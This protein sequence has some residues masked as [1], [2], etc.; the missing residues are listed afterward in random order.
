MFRRIAFRFVRAACLVLPLTLLAGCTTPLFR[1]APEG[2]GT[3]HLQA[4]LAGAAAGS[5]HQLEVHLQHQAQR[6]SEVVPL[7]DG[8]AS[9]SFE[10]LLMGI[11]QV[12][13]VL[14]D[15]DG[16]ITHSGGGNITLFAD[17]VVDASFA[18]VPRPGELRVEIDLGGIPDPALKAAIERARV[19][20]NPGGYSSGVRAE[21]SDVIEITR[22]LAPQS[23]DFQVTLYGEDFLAASRLYASPWYPVSIRPGKVTEVRWVPSVGSV[24]VIGTVVGPP[25]PPEDLRIVSIDGPYRLR[26]TPGEVYGAPVEAGWRI[27]FRENDFEPYRLIDELPYDVTE[28]EFEPPPSSEA[29]RY[30]VA[31]TA[32]AVYAEVPETRFESHRSTIIIYPRS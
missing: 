32:Y 2:S 28:W 29:T 27:Y 5:G 21:G 17:Q 19:N 16:D 15:A 7:V 26:W 6:H 14:R 20:V 13:L 8:R 30:Q 24:N 3:L 23:Y 4:V 22:S 12:E 10:G 18:L 11:W 9:L 25:A 31:V 1:A